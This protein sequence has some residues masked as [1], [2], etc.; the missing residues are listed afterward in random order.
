MMD[1]ISRNFP[2]AQ[3]HVATST[4]EVA[5][6]SAYCVDQPNHISRS[7]RF[8]SY[9]TQEVRETVKV[10][11][12]SERTII[13][14]RE[15]SEAELIQAIKA[16]ALQDNTHYRVKGCVF[17]RDLSGSMLLPKRLSI[18]G[19]LYL[20]RC[21]DLPVLP[22]HL[23]VNGSL[24]L[25]SLDKLTEVPSTI[26]VK[27]RIYIKGCPSLV[28][29]PENHYRYGYLDLEACQQLRRLPHKLEVQQYLNL[30]CCENLTE[31]PEKMFIR[32]YLD[33]RECRRLRCLPKEV[34]LGG[35][36]ILSGCTSLRELPDWVTGMGR[37]WLN[38]RRHVYLSNTQLPVVL[39]DHLRA[40]SVPGMLFHL[41]YQIRRESFAT[42]DQA[43][44][45]WWALSSPPEV[46]TLKQDCR[47]DQIQDL[48]T[49]LERLTETNEYHFPGTRLLLAARVTKA[50]SL[51][52]GSS[53][54]REN[55]LTRIHQGI[56][57]C[58]DRVILALDDLETLQLCQSAETMAL[59]NDDPT[60]LK[61][62]GRQMMILDEV[63]KI[64][65]EHRVS[66][67]RP[68]TLMIEVELAFQIGLRNYFA[69]PGNT[70]HMH[71]RNI[72][73][74]WDHDIA[75][76]A[77]RIEQTCT[78]QALEN[79]LKTWAPWQ[80]YQRNLTIPAFEQLQPMTV[81]RINDCPFC[82]EKTEQMVAFG[83]D[84]FDYHSL[85]RAFLEN[86]SD[87]FFKTP[88]DWSTVYRL[89]QEGPARKKVKFQP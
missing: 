20:Q 41:D 25:I 31:L 56:S 3:Q 38:R 42:I 24:F 76:A 45:F 2:P 18:T 9:A 46:A 34:R 44:A 43:F 50:L 59:Q 74:V 68:V 69:L 13:K 27:G 75:N 19:S 86:S 37:T 71:Y 84:H 49:F 32:G 51:L 17:L 4:T 52:S 88:L 80:K 48:I 87:P 81:D 78:E 10:E 1:T 66:I 35:N 65:R 64:A 60:E 30:A 63:K 16:G 28:T 77:E 36:L 62:L 5:G 82:L 79:Y 54:V 33:L 53:E 55:V 58:E 40:L 39:M 23:T 12:I 83:D 73:G 72:A 89:E 7:I 8:S 21:P 14:F 6:P 67:D 47:P 26:E 22:P 29:L 61:A 57:S 11:V 15:I 85:R 70:R